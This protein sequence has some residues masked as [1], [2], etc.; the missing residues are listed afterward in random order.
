MTVSVSRFDGRADR[1]LGPPPRFE[2]AADPL[3]A[4]EALRVWRA[5][6][7]AQRAAALCR[8]GYWVAAVR[9]WQV[10]DR[11]LD[12]IVVS[13]LGPARISTSLDEL[14]GPG[15]PADFDGI[16][17]ESEVVEPLIAAWQARPAMDLVSELVDVGLTLS[18]ARILAAAGDVTA[19]GAS[20]TA[21]EYSVD[22]GQLAPKAVT[23]IDTVMGRVLVS[24]VA[25][26]DHRPW[27]TVFP[28]TEQR[29]ARAVGELLESLPSGP[30]WT[31]HTRIR[32][33][34]SR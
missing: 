5:S 31:T 9:V 27:T 8:D 28:G 15:Q 30:G 11:P 29:I 20:V 18:Q 26:G 4:A 16:N 33:F 6:R 22:G 24:T 17:I 23:V 12:E 13:P 34:D 3:Q 2:A 14:L 21:T 7:P 10:G 1:L 19:S 32:Q 25:G